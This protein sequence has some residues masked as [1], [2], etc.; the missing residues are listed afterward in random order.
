MYN[1]NMSIEVPEPIHEL[2]HEVADVT[3]MRAKEVIALYL[4]K[5]D[6]KPILDFIEKLMKE[7]VQFVND[8]IA[9]FKEK[10]LNVSEE[11][12]E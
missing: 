9:E 12:S 3:N 8:K 5:D 11:E 7:R 2:I 4:A 6:G 1:K 10:G